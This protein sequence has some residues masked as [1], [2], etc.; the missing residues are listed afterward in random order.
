[1][2]HPG[3]V[4]GTDLG[5]KHNVLRNAASHLAIVL[6]RSG[7]LPSPTGRGIEGRR[8]GFMAHAPRPRS[9]SGLPAAAR[10]ASE[11]AA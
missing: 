1:M 4:G 5:S 8:G 7:F 10:T 2:T 11:G 9:G 3:G 6:A